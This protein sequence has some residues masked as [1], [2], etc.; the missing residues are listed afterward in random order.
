MNASTLTPVE[1]EQSVA[2]LLEVSP[3]LALKDLLE[4]PSPN[5]GVSLYPNFNRLLNEDFNQLLL[6]LMMM[7]LEDK[8]SYHH[9]YLFFGQTHVCPVMTYCS[10]KCVE[11]K[12]GRFWIV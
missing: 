3:V 7:F 12:G 10:I 9:R 4:I 1:E 2:T 8:E 5:A 11:D 6:L